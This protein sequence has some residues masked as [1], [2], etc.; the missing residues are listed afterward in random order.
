MP[1]LLGW[2][3][4]GLVFFELGSYVA[5][6]ISMFQNQVNPIDYIRESFYNRRLNLLYVITDLVHLAFQ[7]LS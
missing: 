2:S 7:I 5:H 6:S 4:T 3:L 1:Q